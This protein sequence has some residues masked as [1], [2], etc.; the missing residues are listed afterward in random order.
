MTRLGG[1]VL[2]LFWSPLCAV[3]SHGPGGPNAQICVS[4]FG[5][6]IVPERPRLLVVLWKGNFTHDLVRE[7]G[8]LAVSVLAEGQEGLLA[9]LGLR[10]GRDGPKLGGLDWGLTPEGD[11]VFGGA[12]GQVR[13][14]VIEGF[15]LGDATAFL[16]GVVGVVDGR[17]GPLRWQAAQRVVGE[18]FLARWAEKSARDRA[19]AAGLLRWL[20]DGAG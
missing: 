10:S 11:P 5:A 15:D 14:R 17:G 6:S 16:V 1:G 20:G 7:A 4:V 19:A 9:P 8:T 18:A 2:S 12:A 3:G 13:G